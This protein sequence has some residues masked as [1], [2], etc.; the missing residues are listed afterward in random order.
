MHSYITEKK[1]EKGPH[2]T[3][4]QRESNVIYRYIL[5]FILYMYNKSTRLYTYI[6][7]GW[8]T[9]DPQTASGLSTFYIWPVLHFLIWSI[10]N[11]NKLIVLHMKH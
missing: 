6:Y 11:K 2:K 1:G 4:R 3:R 7:Q 10:S 9:G 8:A 5:L